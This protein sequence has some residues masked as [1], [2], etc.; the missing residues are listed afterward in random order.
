MVG[1]TSSSS[2]PRVPPLPVRDGVNPTRLRVPR[3]GAWPTIADYVLERFGHVDPEGIR[4]RFRTGEV[5][6]PGGAV[7]DLNTALGAHEFIWYYRDVADEPHLPFE[8]RVLHRDEH[9]VVVDK[10]HF[11]P[12]TPGGRFLQ[13][14]AL[15]RLRRA[16]DHPDLVPLHRLDRAT[17]GVLA[18]SACPDTRGAYQALFENRVVAKTYEAVVRLPD[19]HSGWVDRLPVIYRNRM[20]KT[21]GVITA[22]VVEYPVADSG[23]L[24]APR[25]GKQRRSHAPTVGPNA[26]S[27]IE[28]LG[29]GGGRAHLKLTPHTGRTHQLRVHLAALGTPI[30]HDRF[31]PELL[32]HADDDVD[33]PL[34]LLARTLGFTD[35]L[36]GQPRLFRSELELAEVPR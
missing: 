21:K 2:S 24:P 3:Q 6:A 10:P 16:L 12:T 31:Y 8:V 32:D 30:L 22:Q 1:V 27:R 29:T 26:E 17:A 33:A 35:P 20:E 18:F 4:R 34:Q 23:R 11:L 19:T 15:V 28:L 25:T 36:T 7:V 14:S 13:N 9:L 5:R